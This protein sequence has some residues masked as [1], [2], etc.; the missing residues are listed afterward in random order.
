VSFSRSWTTALRVGQ[1][2]LVLGLVTLN[3]GR[4]LAI[5]SGA[6]YSTQTTLLTARLFE[7]DA[8]PVGE[9]ITLHSEP[10]NYL[11]DMGIAQFDDG[12][13]L[14]SWR[15]MQQLQ[16]HTETFGQLFDW[17]GNPVGE[18]LSLR[19]DDCDTYDLSVASLSQTDLVLV[20]TCD[21]GTIGCKEGVCG[22]LFTTSGDPL[23]GEFQ[24]AP[25]SNPNPSV[26]SFS[27]EGFVVLWSGAQVPFLQAAML[28]QLY[29][30][31]AVKQGLPLPASKWGAEYSWS[32]FSATFEEDRFVAVWHRLTGPSEYE[33]IVRAFQSD[34]TPEGEEFTPTSYLLKAPP[35]PHLASF[36]DNG[37]IVVWTS[38]PDHA[39]TDPGQ[40]GS[41]SGIF[42]Q[43]FNPDGTKKYR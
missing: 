30:P 25:A 9:P 36:A 10:M 39:Y 17:V 6:I 26:S 2:A 41:G 23:G 37:F 42:A 35:H 19:S 38:G 29:G 21:E 1:Y 3:N 24:I 11:V 43:R 20:W 34:A 8:T 28:M 7:H 22:Q 12:S 5:W 32:P 4:F 13:F 18:K 27:D 16:P 33:V 40:D 15:G 31:G 14:L